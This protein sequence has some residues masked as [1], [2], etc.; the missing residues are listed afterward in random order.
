MSASRQK[1]SITNVRLDEKPKKTASGQR[2]MLMAISSKGE[3]KSESK[4][5]GAPQET[6]RPALQRKAG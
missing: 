5:K 3:G 1:R 4:S 2:E 6:K